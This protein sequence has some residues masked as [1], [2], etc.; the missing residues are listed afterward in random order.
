MKAIIRAPLLSVS[1][2]GVHSRQIYSYLENSP[3]NFEI[4]SQIVNWGNT[5]WLINSNLEN[6]MI[7]RIMS[8]ARKLD[9]IA[10]ISFQVQLPDE[11]DPNIAKVNVGVSAV[12]ET[13][14]CQASW[15]ESCNKMDAVIVPSQHAKQCLQNSGKLEVDV[16]VIPEWFFDQILDPRDDNFI[17]SLGVKTK[18]NFLIIIKIIGEKNDRWKICKCYDQYICLRYFL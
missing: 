14:I 18:F 16:H 12:V 6:D 11:W 13:D 15:V 9:G 4:E 10:D 7:G 17:E 8:N 1:G 3:L 2:Y 5:P